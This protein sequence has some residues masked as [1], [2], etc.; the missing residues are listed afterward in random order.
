MTA[1]READALEVL[2]QHLLADDPGIEDAVEA[3]QRTAQFAVQERWLGGSMWHAYGM[4]LVLARWAITQ[5]V[6]SS[7][8]DLVMAARREPAQRD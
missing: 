5:G 1:R 3:A 7:D 6:A 2:F 8:I 4:Q